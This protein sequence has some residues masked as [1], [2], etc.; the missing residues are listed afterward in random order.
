MEE[1]IE[2]TLQQAEGS[3]MGQGSLPEATPDSN[4]PEPGEDH[5]SPMEEDEE[6]EELEAPPPLDKGTATPNALGEAKSPYVFPP[7]PDSWPQPLIQ[8]ELTQSKDVLTKGDF[9][10]AIM[11]VMKEL[12]KDK[13]QG[14]LKA[15][16]LDPWEPTKAHGEVRLFLENLD[17]YLSLHSKADEAT[18]VKVAGTF[19]KGAALMMW[20]QY[21]ANLLR[22]G[23]EP[24]YEDFKS[25]L[26]THY[27]EAHISD[28]AVSQ[29]FELREKEG[30]HHDY[31]VA[32]NALTSKLP[33]DKGEALELVL[34]ALYKRG[35]RKETGS[36]VI[37]D[38][39]TG[40]RHRNLKRLQD[41]AQASSEVKDHARGAALFKGESSKGPKVKRDKG[42]FKKPY[43]G[44][45]K[46]VKGM[47]ASELASKNL[48]FECAEEGHRARDCPKKKSKAFKKQEN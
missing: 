29:M 38:P 40:M 2:A 14:S 36:Q 45:P 5:P 10:E 3:D 34:V 31:R 1:M 44:K 41:Q 7:K 43:K 15:R 21:K 26:L 42:T 48:C 12:M 17:V 32:F 16:P 11:T 23:R 37:L 9:T 30:K 39:S 20:G 22:E 24:T 6:E 27:S 4:V 25:V 13:I 19:L 28:E 46:K 33:Q 47:D 18:K 8:K 35:L